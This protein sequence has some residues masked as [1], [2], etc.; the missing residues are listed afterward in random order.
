MPKGTSLKEIGISLRV[1]VTNITM[2][3][4]AFTWYFLAFNIFRNFL[5]TINVTTWESLVFWGINF[6]GIA[7]SGLI[8]AILVEKFKRRIPFILY[9]MLAGVILSLLPSVL[10]LANFMVLAS[11]STIFGIYFGL[12]MTAC[13][14]YYA[15]STFTENRARLGGIMFLFIGLGFFLLG[16]ITV[17]DIFTQIAVLAVW[18]GIGFL[19][20]VLLK[21][22]ENPIEK[23]DK[24]SYATIISKQSFLLYFIPWCMFSLVNYV[25][26]PVTIEFF[27]EEF[28]VFSSLIEN[29]LIATFA[30]ISGFLADLFGRKRLTIMGFAVL[31]LGYAVLGIYP[32]NSLSWYLYTFIDGIA[33]GSFYTIFLIV[34][35]GDLAR[36]QRSEKYYAIG[37]LP[38]LF[39]NFVRVIVESYVVEAVSVFT[40]FSFASFFLFLAVIPLMYAP[41]TLP[42][43]RIKEMEL[44]NYIEKAKKIK[45]K[46]T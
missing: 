40:I 1:A 43:K 45:E 31:G 27:G 46:F 23:T 36:G 20:L 9:W 18:R 30:V 24:K 15:D 14:G 13:M 34:L 28:V 37:S 29:L 25:T 26:I 7:V 38:F 44:R 32:E 16:T 22:T 42:E 35:W 39:S 12:G 8:G 2:I 21:P 41:E 4:N 5:G 3:G 19:V 11:V 10:D 17:G 6:A 33:W